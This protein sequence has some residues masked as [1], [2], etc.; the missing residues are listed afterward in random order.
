MWPSRWFTPTSGRPC[1]HA[2]AFASDVPTS[3]EPTS[4]GPC[5]TA[6]PSRSMSRTRASPS[7]RSTTGTI[8][9]RCRRDAS[10][11]T[12][13]PYGPW[14]SSCEATTLDRM[15]RPSTSTAAAVS[16]HELSI[17]STTICRTASKFSTGR[18]KDE[19]RWNDAHRPS[20]LRPLPGRRLR[21]RGSLGLALASVRTLLLDQSHRLDDV[22]GALQLHVL[23]EILHRVRRR[24][25]PLLRRRLLRRLHDDVR[26]DS[27]AV[28]RASLGRE[29]LR[30]RQPKP[31]AIRERDDRLHRSLAERLRAHDHRAA[32]ILKRAGDDLGGRGAALVDQDHHRHLGIALLGV[33]REAHVLVAHAAFRVD[34]QLAVVDELLGHLDGRRQQPARV[35]AQIQ[36][37]RL[38]PALVELVERLVEVV[39]ALLLELA[40]LDVRD[41]VAEVLRAHRVHADLLARDL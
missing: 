39:R 9:S 20:P 29:V 30:R 23:L 35:V 19:R 1:T 26:R 16:S 11:G 21:R 40:Q 10:S 3:S 12:T 7:A 18:R 32:P 17:P 24:Q 25:R 4:P 2:S 33:S 37:Q 5:V 34:D 28:D 8:T 36:D 6:M 27:L 41:A 22:K 38:H 14:T 15:R 13:P 31:R